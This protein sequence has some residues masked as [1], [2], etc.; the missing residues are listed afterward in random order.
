[1]SNDKDYE[2]DILDW[3]AIYDG[4]RVPQKPKLN[5]E[6]NRFALSAEDENWEDG[7]VLLSAAARARKQL[8]PR[9]TSIKAETVLYDTYV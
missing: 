5:P 4:K 1:M 8:N 7:S 9:F 2:D 6:N 3:D